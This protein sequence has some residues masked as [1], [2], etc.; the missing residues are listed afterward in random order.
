[1]II[2][3]IIYL[4][5]NEIPYEIPRTP[6]FNHGSE[7][8]CFLYF[9]PLCLRPKHRASLYWLSL[10][11]FLHSSAWIETGRRAAIPLVFIQFWSWRIMKITNF[12]YWVMEPPW[13]IRP[14]YKQWRGRHQEMEQLLNIIYLL[15]KFNMQIIN[16][17]KYI[18]IWV[19]EWAERKPLIALFGNLHLLVIK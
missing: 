6:S 15:D 19:I 4:S 14:I 9:S 17:E 12:Q 11:Y 10:L 2:L 7:T 13:V 5:R 3:R 16:T 8:N 18:H 1:M